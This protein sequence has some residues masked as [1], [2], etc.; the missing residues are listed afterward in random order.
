MV[1]VQR[2]LLFCFY[3]LLEKLLWRELPDRV[4]V[5]TVQTEVRKH[6]HGEQPV[7]INRQWSGMW[8]EK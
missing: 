5:I 3:L 1:K 4:Q 8:V 6:F 2:P 7:R